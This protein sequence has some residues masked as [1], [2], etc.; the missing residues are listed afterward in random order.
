MLL[1]LEWFGLALAKEG[2]FVGASIEATLQAGLP[3]RE[4]LVFE[5]MLDRVAF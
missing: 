5:E 2:E 1:R 3:V 4:G